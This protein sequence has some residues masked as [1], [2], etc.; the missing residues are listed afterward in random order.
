MKQLLGK[1]IWIILLSIVVI[2]FVLIYDFRHSRVFPPNDMIPFISCIEQDTN[3]SYI[4]HQWSLRNGTIAFSDNPLFNSSENCIDSLVWNGDQ[5]ILL[6]PSVESSITVSNGSSFHPLYI[7]PKTSLSIQ[8]ILR[9]NLSIQ[10][11]IQD[12]SKHTQATAEY[13]GYKQDKITLRPDIEKYTNAVL[14]RPLD[15]I[16]IEATTYLYFQFAWLDHET[17][18]KFGIVEG[19]WSDQSLLWRIVSD[20]IEFQEA[21]KGSNVVVCQG[22]I[23]FAL[24]DGS[25]RSVML[26]NG[27]I[28]NQETLEARID[29]DTDKPIQ[30]EL[31]RYQNAV[32]MKK[33][34]SQS[35]CKI[36]VVENNTPTS[37]I[38]VTKDFITIFQ[39]EKETMVYQNE[40]SF[41]N[42]YKNP[43][44]W[45]F[46]IF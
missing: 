24:L 33:V 4:L 14:I 10:L 40:D 22:R 18:L 32:I 3:T 17:N 29:L 41:K 44:N 9:P 15:A 34:Y 28:E 38:E 39:N 42:S 2:V 25:I 11:S 26:H 21:G 27:S 31:F 1:N 13:Y 5:E 7:R 23:W 6:P 12:Y 45:L 30:A 37:R 20:D 46:P 16:E 19:Q 36:L 43:S 35:S 8:R